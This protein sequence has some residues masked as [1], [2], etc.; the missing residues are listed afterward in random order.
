MDLVSS[1]KD[2]LGYFRVKELKDV[3]THL[4]LGKQGRKQDL[5]DR[6]LAAI[7]DDQV[8]KSKKNSIGKEGIAKIIEDTYRKMQT[9]GATDLASKGQ[10]DS[11]FDTAKFKDEV[12]DSRKIDIKVQCPC[13]SSLQTESMIQCEDP[14]CQV[15]QHIGCVVIPD[16]PTE[17]VPPIPPQFLC[18]IC[19]INRAD[20]FW[21]TVTYP[22]P[23][24]K[25]T[26][27]SIP[28]DGTNP[29][30]NVEKTFQLTRAD[31]DMV[32]KPEY[33]VQAWCMLLNDKVIFRM[34]WPQFSDLQVNGVPVR[35]INR[36]GSQLL[37]ANGRDDGPAITTC[38][39]EGMNKISLTG[40]DARIFCL[41]VRIAKR[42]TV[43]QVLNLIPK[44]LDGERF[45]DAHARVCRCIG[46]GN[47][48]ENA[49]SDSDL[50]VVAD[51]VTVNLR[52]P[53][54]G[55]RIKIAGR[56]KPC[57]H[58]GCFDLETFVE[59]NQRSR[60]W[61]CPICLK[62]YTL[63]HMIIDP[64]FNRITAMMGRCG[65][66][67]TEIDVKPDG[68]W[69]AK[70][71]REHL[72]LAQWHFP[73]GSLC[74]ETGKNIK[75]DLE[76]SKQIKHDGPLEGQSPFKLGIKKNSNGTWEVKKPELLTLSPESQLEEKYDIHSGGGIL[77]SSSG[78][79]SARDIDDRN[80]NRDAGGQFNFLANNGTELDS[81]SPNFDSAYEVPSAPVGNADIII[82]SDSDEEM[83]NLIS[84]GAV[85]ETGQSNACGTSFSVPSLGVPVSYP[86][87]P[88]LIT[89]SA[90][91]LLNS[92][93]DEF[94]I[95]LWPSVASCTHAGPGFQFFGTE[96]D[97][98]D[99]LEDVQR[100][101]INCPTST[102]GGFSLAPETTLGSAI[103]IS[104]SICHSDTNI[105]GV[106]IDNSLTIGEDD[107]SLQI[108]LPT[109]PTA[110]SAPTDARDPPVST[111]GIREEDWISLRVGDGV[112]HDRSAATNGLN[113]G[114]E[115]VSKE[116]SSLPS[117]N[118]EMSDRTT[119][120]QQK[121]ASPFSFPRQARS[122][123]PRLYLSIDSDSD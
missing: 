82:L 81:V 10:S 77:R 109:H 92:N 40:C 57:I 71:D 26:A 7:T 49:D 85:F 88:G 91:D 48:T 70:N 3:L 29:M 50:E 25:L 103:Q 69:R 52:C 1:C 96:T 17:G 74:V 117:P 86:E 64:Y 36:P 22:L 67:V 93:G 34:H 30:Q 13:G 123:R 115:S 63:E 11:S 118:D 90:L 104:E 41:G 5:M 76:N 37:G 38:T 108:F 94:E 43:Q 83:E 53:M 95:P 20:P 31:R 39:R 110:S 89:D 58:M 9:S 6:I 23:P 78:T 2:K 19:R 27:L 66:D 54:S 107:P 24:I 12:V 111:N 106:L 100:T 56:F 119:T 8:T 80:A 15:W 46:G 112:G 42:R 97:V 28:T 120:N 59:L 105:N 16:K 47:D 44:E 18:E 84:H 72:D 32:Q 102:N 65:E 61:Q 121:S 62:N 113:A 4:G 33:D 114:H 75:P 116:A 87:D 35:S 101:S 68:S 79:G 73:D 98:S 122:V 51:S 14:R 60:K 21:L 55:S 45:E 99:S